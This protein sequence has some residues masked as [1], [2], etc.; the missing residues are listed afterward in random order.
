ML[1]DLTRDSVKLFRDFKRLAIE[2]YCNSFDVKYKP[3]PDPMMLSDEITA[4]DIV[5]ALNNRA[6]I[7]QFKHQTHHLGKRISERF[8]QQLLDF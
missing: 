7:S 2:T 6:A 8:N 3:P 5:V 4:R 1:I